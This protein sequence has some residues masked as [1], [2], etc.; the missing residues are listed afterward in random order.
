MLYTEYSV[1]LIVLPTIS[2]GAMA[3]TWAVCLEQCVVS[4]VSWE[5]LKIHFVEIN[6]DQQSLNND[7]DMNNDVKYGSII[8][9]HWLCSSW[10]EFSSHGLLPAGL[11]LNFPVLVLTLW[12]LSQLSGIG[13]NSPNLRLSTFMFWFWTHWSWSQLSGI[14]FNSPIL[15]LNQFVFLSTFWYWP[16]FSGLSLNFLVFVSTFWSWFQFFG[17]S[18]EP[19]PLG[20]H[21]EFFCLE[22][23]VHCRYNS[24]FLL[25]EK[26]RL[27]KSFKQIFFSLWFWRYDKENKMFSSN[28]NQMN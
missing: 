26:Y 13:F 1:F 7:V 14:G 18:L 5:D 21:F 28:A 2:R 24:V 17:F 4:S 19:T 6:C 22:N 16:Q 20:L 10:S 11:V 8:S 9:W 12:S 25:P 27:F 3:Y 15:V 23:Y